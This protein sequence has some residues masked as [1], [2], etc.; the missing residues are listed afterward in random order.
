MK[1]ALGVAG[2][3]IHCGESQTRRAIHAAM[4]KPHTASET[5]IAGMP[6]ALTC[7]PRRRTSRVLKRSPLLLTARRSH[8]GPFCYFDPGGD[9]T[10]LSDEARESKHTY[11]PS[12]IPKLPLPPPR[13]R[14]IVVVNWKM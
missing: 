11:Q 3:A 5:M 4:A 10:S 7:K 1:T 13:D 6:E 14:K 9:R 12:R 8:A 2:A